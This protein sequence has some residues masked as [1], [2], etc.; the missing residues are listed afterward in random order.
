VAFF[1]RFLL[2]DP[3]CLPPEGYW[4]VCYYLG[5]TKIAAGRGRD[6]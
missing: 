4:G 5:Q 1:R 2:N 6:G 3:I